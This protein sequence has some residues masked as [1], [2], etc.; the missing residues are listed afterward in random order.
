MDVISLQEAERIKTIQE[1]TE[2][3]WKLGLPPGLEGTIE[4]IKNDF[5]FLTSLLDRVAKPNQAA[6][7]CCTYCGSEIA[8][9][10]Q[11]LGNASQDSEHTGYACD[12]FL[13]CRAEWDKFGNVT[14]PARVSENEE[15]E[16][17]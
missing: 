6:K 3:E 13:N 14:I 7:L 15:G 2:L 11:W 12:D 4:S 8:P 16:L 9:T 10:L 17:A 5:R 1:T